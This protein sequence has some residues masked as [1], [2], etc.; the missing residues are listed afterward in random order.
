MTDGFRADINE[1]AVEEQLANLNRSSIRLH[2]GLIC[3]EKGDTSFWGE[4]GLDVWSNGASQWIS[5]MLGILQMRQI[6]PSQSGWLEGPGAALIQ[7]PGY[8]KFTRI[9]YYEFEDNTYHYVNVGVSGK[10]VKSNIPFESILTPDTH[11]NL[12]TFTLSLQTNLDRGFWW[13][14][15]DLPGYPRI[16]LDFP[17]PGNNTEPVLVTAHLSIEDMKQ[18]QLSN[19]RG[20]FLR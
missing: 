13:A 2:I 12:T 19:W 18:G 5:S 4:H 6:L 14:E 9:H 15:Y 7:L 1:D 20:C 17:V 8:A 16:D 11:C 3:P 10:P